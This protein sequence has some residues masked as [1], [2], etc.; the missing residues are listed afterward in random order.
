V[1][2]ASKFSSLHCLPV[3]SAKLDFAVRATFSAK[4]GISNLRY[5][6]R[7]HQIEKNGLGVQLPTSKP[8]GGEKQ[9]LTDGV[10]MGAM[11]SAP[12]SQAIFLSR[13]VDLLIADEQVSSTFGSCSAIWFIKAGSLT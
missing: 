13:L 12:F 10:V 4:T 3:F 5:H 9:G 1:I 6:L 2:Y 11:T 8:V 7:G